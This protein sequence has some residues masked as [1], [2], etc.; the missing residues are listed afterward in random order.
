MKNRF[1]EALA[2]EAAANEATIAQ[3]EAEAINRANAE[4]VRD[5]PVNDIVQTTND[6]KQ[7]LV[8]TTKKEDGSVF[9]LFSG[10]NWQQKPFIY[11]NERCLAMG[12]TEEEIAEDERAIKVALAR[13]DVNL[14][15]TFAGLISG[16]YVV[17]QLNINGVNL[18]TQGHTEIECAYDEERAR[19]AA[20]KLKGR[21][22]DVATAEELIEAELDPTREFEK[23]G[24][25]YIYFKFSKNAR[26]F[27]GD[28]VANLNDITEKLSD[29]IAIELLK[30]RIV[31][32]TYDEYDEYDDYNEYDDD[33]YE[34]Y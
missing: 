17:K 22:T 13:G 6:V 15:R 18:L 14:Q 8:Y 20:A 2:A 24:I 3:N 23:D 31:T 9:G 21:M 33:E 1:K 19:I 30:A 10:N 16:R 32:P 25:R 27:D 26:N 11:N 12:C 4:L 7:K 34:E 28:E 5:I 29:D